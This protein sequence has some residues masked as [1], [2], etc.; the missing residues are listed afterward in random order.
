ME[1]ME[2][3]VICEYK[4]ILDELILVKSELNEK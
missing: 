2:G 4:V 3:R 1:V